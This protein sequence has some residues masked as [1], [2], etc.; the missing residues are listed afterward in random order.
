M[1]YKIRFLWFRLFW[2]LWMNVNFIPALGIWHTYLTYIE[3]IMTSKY[4]TKFLTDWNKL[5]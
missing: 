2:E 1:I 4:S 3:T 5:T